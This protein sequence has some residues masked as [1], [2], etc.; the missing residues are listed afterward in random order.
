MNNYMKDCDIE[1]RDLSRDMRIWPRIKELNTEYHDCFIPFRD[2]LIE[3][4]EFEQC[5]KMMDHEQSF[6]VHGM[7]GAGK[8]GCIENIIAYCEEKHIP[9]LAIK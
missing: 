1:Y 3:R 4:D 5:R 9:H 6:V 7:A 2:G 8:S